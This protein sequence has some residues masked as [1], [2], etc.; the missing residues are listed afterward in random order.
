MDALGKEKIITALEQAL[1][2]ASKLLKEHIEWALM[3]ASQVSNKID[4]D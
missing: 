4:E 2:G 1:P 3:Q